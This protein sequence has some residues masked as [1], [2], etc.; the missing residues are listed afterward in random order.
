VKFPG[1]KREH[2]STGEK[3]VLWEDEHGGKF[4]TKSLPNALIRGEEEVGGV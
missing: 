4:I 3:E 2:E 1:Q